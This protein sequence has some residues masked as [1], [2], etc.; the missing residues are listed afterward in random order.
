MAQIGASDAYLSNALMKK[1]PGMLNIPL[2]IS[3]QMVNYNVPGLNGDHL[4]LSGPV[5]AGIY[6]GKITK[7]NDPAIA[8]INPGVKLPDHADRADPPHRR[9]R[10]HLHLHPVPV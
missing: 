6:E 10:R 3:S 5:L 8:K 1:H 9:Q 7:W 4:K 2:A